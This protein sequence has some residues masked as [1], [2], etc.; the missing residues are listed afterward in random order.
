[1]DSVTHNTENPRKRK[2][3]PLQPRPHP[4]D[5][6]ILAVLPAGNPFL[7]ASV[8][9]STRKREDF[10]RATLNSRIATLTK[11]CNIAASR[12]LYHNDY[13]TIR[14][15]MSQKDKIVADQGKRIFYLFLA[16]DNSHAV[17]YILERLVGDNH[18]LVQAAGEADLAFSMRKDAAKGNLATQQAANWLKDVGTA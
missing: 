14:K 12:P 15:E 8:S 9:S 16:I 7:E 11:R 13:Q 6:E 18:N 5:A 1:M 2:A 4:T 10:E 17:H 3:A